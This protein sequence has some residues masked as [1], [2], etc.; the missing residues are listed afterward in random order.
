MVQKTDRAPANAEAFEAAIL[1][2]MMIDPECIEEVRAG[3]TDYTFR[4]ERFTH[5]YH[6]I[7][8]LWACG[9]KGEALDVRDELEHRNLLDEVKVETIAR[10][11][12]A[13]PNG[14]N[15]MLYVAELT[16]E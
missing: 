4:Q 13:V 10:V 12:D 8:T 1:G 14:A 16:K 15:V 3:L 5:I 6:A 9:E 2:A 7:L 11:L